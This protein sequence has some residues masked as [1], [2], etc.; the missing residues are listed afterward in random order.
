MSVPGV[1]I[2]YPPL[3]GSSSL[4]NSLRYTVSAVSY[5]HLD[6]YKRQDEATGALDIV[7]KREIQN[8]IL[9][10]Y[11]NAKFDPTILNV[12]HSII[13]TNF[14]RSLSTNSFRWKCLTRTPMKVAKLINTEL[15]KYK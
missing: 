14:S 10:I 9:D 2:P 7:M 5:T 3:C 15:M 1:R 13:L 4:G 8:T 6:V 12:T 11:Y